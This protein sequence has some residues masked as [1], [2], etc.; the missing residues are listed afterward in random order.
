MGFAQAASGSTIALDGVNNSPAGIGLRGANTATTGD[1]IGV[2]GQ[3]ES[4][5]GAAVIAKGPGAMERFRVR[6]DGNVGINTATQFG[7]GTGVIGIAN[8]TDAPT[9]NPATGGVL[10]VEGGALKYR[11]SAG[12]VTTI[13]NA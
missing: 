9:S 4:A 5:A 6:G 13:A 1:A 11:G 3:T 10:Y 2:Q 8:R 12:T 7:G